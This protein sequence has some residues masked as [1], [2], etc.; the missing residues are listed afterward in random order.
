MKK[1]SPI[2]FST[3][4]VQAILD[5]RKDVTRRI[6]TPQPGV[7]DCTQRVTLNSAG[8]WEAE[9]TDQQWKCKYGQ[10]GDILWVK[11][12]HCFLVDTDGYTHWDEYLYK[13]DNADVIA[14][15]A[16]GHRLYRKDGT[17]ASPWRSPRFMPK[18]AARIWLEITDLRVERVQDITEEQAKKEGAQR[19]TFQRT[20]FRTWFRFIWQKI[21]GPESWESNPWVWVIAF[22]QIENP[23]E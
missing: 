11:E 2:L 12:S 7:G 9:A 5:G 18:D 15:D 16:N 17:E 14:R 20:G 4:M 1:Q 22:K 21:N 10:V 19:H 23:N 6:M 3:E 8:L 13:A